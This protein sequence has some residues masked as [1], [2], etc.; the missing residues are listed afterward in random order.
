MVCALACILGSGW[1]A[2]DGGRAG[3]GRRRGPK[4]EAP[5]RGPANG[6]VDR[7]RTYS[8]ALSADF[9]FA[10]RGAQWRCVGRIESPRIR[11][12]DLGAENASR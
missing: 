3:A 10:F 8:A 6:S 5:R 7:E 12:A 2:V 4:A 11:G 9:C 1:Q